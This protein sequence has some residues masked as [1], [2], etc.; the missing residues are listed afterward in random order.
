MYPIINLGVITV[1]CKGCNFQH[2]ISC[3]ELGEVGMPNCQH[4]FKPMKRLHKKYVKKNLV[5]EVAK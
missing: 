1:H 5:A 2:Q 4:C 3:R